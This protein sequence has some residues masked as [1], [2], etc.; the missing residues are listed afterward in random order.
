[1]LLHALRRNLDVIVSLEA[2]IIIRELITGL[3]YGK[4]CFG[5]DTKL[6]L[7]R[8]GDLLSTFGANIRVCNHDG[9]VRQGEDRH[10]TCTFEAIGELTAVHTVASV[11]S[12][13]SHDRKGCSRNSH[14]K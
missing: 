11:C 1:M 9:R 14:D 10:I 12:E 13:G 4:G 7:S 8:G 5:W 2:I 3:R 6:I